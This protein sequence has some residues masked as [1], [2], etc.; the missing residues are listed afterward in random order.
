MS[1]KRC[2]NTA[3]AIAYLGI[4]RR[5]FELHILPLLQSKGFRI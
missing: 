3:E 1:A 5:S 2:F 4:K